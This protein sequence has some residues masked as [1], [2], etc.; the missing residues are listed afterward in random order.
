MRI[1]RQLAARSQDSLGQGIPDLI[2]SLVFALPAPHQ[3]CRNHKA[4]RSRL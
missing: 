3:Y 1:F 2:F 4:E